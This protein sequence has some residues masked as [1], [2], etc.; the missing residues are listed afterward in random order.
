LDFYAIYIIFF[1]LGNARTRESNWAILATRV[2]LTNCAQHTI[3]QLVNW[4]YIVT[5]D[6]C[7]Y[8]SSEKLS[9]ENAKRLLNAHVCGPQNCTT[10]HIKLMKVRA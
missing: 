2:I 1:K 9:E 10:G 6:K 3:G 7:G 4:N 8:I 5:C